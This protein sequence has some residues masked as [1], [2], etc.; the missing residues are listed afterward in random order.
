MNVKSERS[1]HVSGEF[2]SDVALIISVIA[3]TSH[4]LSVYCA[5]IFGIVEL[6]SHLLFTVT[7]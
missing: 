6:L 5:V 7:F 3:D 1:V 2:F 4:V